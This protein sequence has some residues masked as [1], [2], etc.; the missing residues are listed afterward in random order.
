MKSFRE[1]VT[2]VEGPR[3]ELDKLAFK[4]HPV[5]VKDYPVANA[6]ERDVKTKKD[7]SRSADQ[8]GGKDVAAYAADNGVKTDP[9]SEV[10]IF[11]SGRAYSKQQIMQYFKPESVEESFASVQKKI[12]SSEHIPMKNAGAILAN[13][14]RHASAAAKR[15]NPKLKR[16]KEEVEID[17]ISDVLDQLDEISKK[18]LGDYINAASSD[19]SHHAHEIGKVNQIA[20]TD[21]TTAADR[22][23]RDYHNK[24]HSKRSGGIGHAVQKLTKEEVAV[25]DDCSTITK[26]KPEGGSSSGR[27]MIKKNKDKIKVK[28]AGEFRESFRDRVEK[29]HPRETKPAP[30]ERDGK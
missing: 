9:M 30:E 1:Y 24:Q 23:H 10:P 11:Q 19:K 28:T 25:G 15:K 29:K 27:S 22:A 18:R 4:E 12:S 17:D 2:E 7:K 26:S 14:S 13:A 6:G 16:V 5:Q 8:Q 3:S 20:A 21:G